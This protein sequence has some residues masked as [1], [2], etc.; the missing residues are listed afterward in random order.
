MDYLRLK[1]PIV[2]FAIIVVNDFGANVS[3]IYRFLRGDDVDKIAL[4][5]FVICLVRCVSSEVR[6]GDCFFFDFLLDLYH[7]YL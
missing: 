3:R 5:V 6:L 2:G 7:R 1:D 4:A